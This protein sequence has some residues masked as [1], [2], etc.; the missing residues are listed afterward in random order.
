MIVPA[1]YY[2][3]QTD[4]ELISFADDL[5]A[6]ILARNEDEARTKVALVSMLVDN[7]L[8]DHGL[9]LAVQK[10]KMVVLTRQRALP[11]NFIVQIASHNIEATR[12]LKYLGVMVD[13]KLT[14]WLQLC[15][16][17]DKAGTLVAMLSR[18]MPNIAGP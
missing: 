15:K 9:K 18:M 14:F 6:V 16:A 13:Q 3:N 10:T 8:K 11:D 7:W 2:Q 17:A 12:V 5:A 4:C 1:N